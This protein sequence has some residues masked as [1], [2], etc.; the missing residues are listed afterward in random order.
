MLG[1]LGGLGPA[2]SNY[3]MERLTALRGAKIDQEHPDVL[4]YSRASTPDRTSFLTG[5]SAV[6]PLPALLDS[7]ERL[8][9][10]GAEVL[11]MPCVTAHHFFSELSE[12]SGGKLINMLEETASLLRNEGVRRAGLLATTGSLQSGA[13][14][15]VL[16]KAGI[17]VLVPDRETQ[18]RLMDLIYAVKSGKMPRTSILEQFGARLSAQGAQRVILGCT[19]LSLYTSKLDSMCFVDTIEVLAA[20]ALE[21]C[22]GKP[23]HIYNVPRGN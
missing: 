1:V 12:A 17:D 22:I 6:S 13:F 8:N 15:K 7:I 11:A 3:F 21:L 9:R 10:A 5:T 20:R 19:E 14:E 4:L 18:S 2:A 23:V 16:Y